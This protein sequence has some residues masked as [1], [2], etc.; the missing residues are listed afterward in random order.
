MVRSDWQLEIKSLE[1]HAA[2][3]VDAALKTFSHSIG[4]ECPIEIGAMIRAPER[5]V[6]FP[7]WA[8]VSRFVEKAAL[9]FRVKR[10]NYIFEIARYDEYK[11]LPDKVLPSL[12]GEFS[13]VP[14]TTW[15]ASLF[16]PNW[17]NL[18]GQHANLP[19]GASTACSADLESFFTPQE[20]S[21]TLDKSENFWQFI[22]L[23]KS[24][25]EILGS[26]HITSTSGQIVLKKHPSPAKGSHIIDSDLGTLF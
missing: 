6:T 11:R 5:K 14:F 24:V 18:L 1:F 15:G 23:V 12:P 10:T 3:T 9:R 20:Q 17:D 7:A 22:D 19:T 16:D 21:A 8:P 26:N 4:F 2:S 25:A 13:K